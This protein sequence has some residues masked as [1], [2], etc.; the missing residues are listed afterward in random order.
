[1]R[2]TALRPYRC[3]AC[4]RVIDRIDPRWSW[5]RA[6]IVIRTALESHTPVCMSVRALALPPASTWFRSG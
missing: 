6:V 4:G 1:M 5:D 2:T 3:P